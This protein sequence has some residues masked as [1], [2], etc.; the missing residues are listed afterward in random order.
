MKKKERDAFLE[1][2]LAST[3]PEYLQSIKEARA[4]YKAGRTKTH[5]E[6]FGNS[7]MSSFIPAG[8]IERF[9]SS[10]SIDLTPSP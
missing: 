9:R 7:A 6:V 1:D 3:S 8:Q 10:N 5:I 4:D 2:L